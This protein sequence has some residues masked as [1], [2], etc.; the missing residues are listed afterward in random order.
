MEVSSRASLGCSAALSSPTTL[1]RHTAKLLCANPCHQEEEQR[2][3]AAAEIWAIAYWVCAGT[4]LG[5]GSEAAHPQTATGRLN[6]FRPVL[7]GR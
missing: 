1:G 4:K 7:L 5:L 2:E 3:G 6:P